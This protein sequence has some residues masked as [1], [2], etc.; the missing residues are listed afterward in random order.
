MQSPLYEL[1]NVIFES[2]NFRPLDVKK[3]EVHR[4][5]VYSIS[6]KPGSGKTVFL[7]VLSRN[8]RHSSGEIKFESKDISQ[9]SNSELSD[10]IA[11]VRQ[12]NKAPRWT[13]VESYILKVLD[14]YSHTR[15]EK[16]KRLAR[17]INQMEIKH[18]L[19]RP[20][21]KLTPG[22][23]RWVILSAMIAADAKVLLIDEIEQ[24][25]SPDAVNNLVR[26]LYRKS[27][28]DG[29]TVIITTQNP[30]ILK[31]IVTIFITMNSGRITSVRSAKKP[32]KY[33]KRKKP[34]Q[35]NKKD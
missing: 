8:L 9:V 4:G 23:L 32:R 10:Q 6:G 21:R 2:G 29:I 3:F 31:K 5:T 11:F 18:L 19:D 20:M 16:K 25:L 22:Q 34:N 1:N 7:D 26:I 33:N 24:H 17:I 30:E 35:N 13:T 15:N 14:S 28:Y 12:I 27:N